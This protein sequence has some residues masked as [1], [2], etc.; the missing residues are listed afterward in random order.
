MPF[1]DLGN[2]RLEYRLILGDGARPPLVFLHEG[3]GSAALWRDFPDK[4]A[5][6]TGARALV[7][8]R[9]GYGRSSGLTA[10]RTPRYLHEEALDVLPRLLAALGIVRPILIGHSDGASIALIHAAHH[11]DAVAG[12][13]L[14]APHVF[15]EPISLAG[16]AA[17][18]EL[19][20]TGG[21]RERLA[22]HHDHVD[23][24][25]HGWAD[26]WLSP[27]FTSW[28]LAREVETL[29]APTLLIQGED[30]PYGTLTQL[31][32]FEAARKAKITRLVLR[33]CGHSP[34]RDQE[35]K[36]IEALTD[37][38]GGCPTGRSA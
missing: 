19:Y 3:L 30:D 11:P 27:T 13:V 4:V 26:T 17:T 15:V 37:F 34:Q 25:F 33:D 16:I 36:V 35:A 28:S 5:R 32:A 9:A 38:L 14:M 31:D 7:Y 8:S 24:A 6:R 18:A 21:L 20:E 1:A 22:K 2:C 10:K 29:E 12:L 23:D